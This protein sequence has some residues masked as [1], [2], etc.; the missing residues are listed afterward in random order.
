MK[1][2]RRRCG[3]VLLALLSL[4]PCEGMPSEAGSPG[5]GNSVLLALRISEA[6]KQTRRLL[7]Y[8]SLAR[9]RRG[10]RKAPPVL[11]ARKANPANPISA[12]PRS[13]KR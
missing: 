4:F 11:D 7:Y 5:R 9:R 10:P 13:T 2:S 8:K 12:R 3:L 1:A 6:R